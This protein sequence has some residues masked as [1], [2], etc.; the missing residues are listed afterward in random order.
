MK[1]EFRRQIFGKQAQ[2]FMKF[3]PVGAELFHT[4]GE[5]GRQKNGRMDGLETSSRFSKFCE[6]S[7]NAYVLVCFNFR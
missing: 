5:T 3:R 6:R 1:L 4:D 2:I 7:K